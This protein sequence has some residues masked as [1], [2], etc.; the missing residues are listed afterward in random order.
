MWSF[1]LGRHA[2][3][4][5]R[6]ALSR[7]TLSV[8]LCCEN[9][10]YKVLLSKFSVR[11]FETLLF[12]MVYAAV[13]RLKMDL[14]EIRVFTASPAASQQG[15][16]V[17]V[18]QP[19]ARQGARRSAVSSWSGSENSSTQNGK[20]RKGSSNTCRSLH[21]VDN[22]DSTR[23]ENKVREISDRIL[24]NQGR[25]QVKKC[26]VDTHGERAEREHIT[27]VWGHSSRVKLIGFA[28]ISGTTS[29]KSGVDMSTPV[30][31]VATPL[32]LTL[33]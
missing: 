19:G 24:L 33:L 18:P 20:P 32:Q 29:G 27:G 30:H 21:V 25:R 4:G 2:S 1:A 31:P 14:P 15:C 7:C 5:W 23:R 10:F 13:E 17:D 16:R 28:S 8:L 3:N 9:A 11:M 12:R 22:D 6:L 26:G